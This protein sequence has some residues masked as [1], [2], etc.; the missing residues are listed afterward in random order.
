MSAQKVIVTGA[1]RG[2]DI[3]NDRYSARDACFGSKISVGRTG[4]IG[5]GY[6]AA[7]LSDGASYISGD[8]ITVTR[9]AG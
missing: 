1:S 5:R 7:A 4:R 8:F 9:N 6:P 3:L 2:T